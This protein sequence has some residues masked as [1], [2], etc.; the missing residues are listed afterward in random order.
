MKAL[1][2]LVK[3]FEGLHTLRRDGLV[4]PYLCP[5][6]H[7]T[8][9]WGLL[10]P[11]M[12]A[13][14]ITREEADRRMEAA[15]PA[16]VA[17]TLKLVPNLRHAPPDVL[18]AV[19]DFTFNLGAGKLRASTLRRRLL[20]EDWEGARHELRKWVFGGGKKLPGLVRR[21]AAEAAL[22]ALATGQ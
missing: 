3:T 7:P 22:I 2:G 17:Q 1:V 12:K 20:A 13:P 10:V 11:D 16:Y 14:P 9:G 21:R 19:S 4:Y 18:A 15:L 6:G 8:Q 5:A